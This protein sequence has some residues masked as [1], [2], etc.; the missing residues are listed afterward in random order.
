MCYACKIIL[1]GW[2]GL[3]FEVSFGTLI[4]LTREEEF[5]IERVYLRCLIVIPRAESRN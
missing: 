2:L 5:K 1:S 4:P 3:G